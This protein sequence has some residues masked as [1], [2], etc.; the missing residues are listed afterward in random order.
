MNSELA[1]GRA[2]SRIRF[3]WW[4]T[5]LCPRVLGRALEHSEIAK[6]ALVA[7][8]LIEGGIDFLLLGEVTPEAA[9][10]IFNALPRR[11]VLQLWTDTEDD[12]S[13]PRI[14]AL[15]NRNV[16]LDSSP[17]ILSTPHSE[18]RDL[19][20]T[21][22]F[23]ARTNLPGAVPISVLAVHWHSQ[24]VPQE[25]ERQTLAGAVK[26][27]VIRTLRAAKRSPILVLGDFNVEPYDAIMLNTLLASRHH[28]FSRKKLLYNCAWRWLGEGAP[29][30]AEPSLGLAKRRG[31]HYFRGAGS[32]H[33]YDQAMVS[34][35]LL[36]TIAGSPRLI[37][38]ESGVLFDSRIGTG[39]MRRFTHMP[40][41]VTIGC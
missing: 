16:I 31:T 2:P 14:A 34:R 40:I 6:A 41:A 29:V 26:E 37:E 18:D 17:S 36:S 7:D 32:W 11:Q 33:L 30:D 1:Q 27:V 28:Q 35:G 24:M 15:Y 4:N 39:Q 3:G 10:A 5:D 9:V 25:D 19:A 13:R 20:R 8:R 23:Q 12:I 38:S 21:V 22:Q